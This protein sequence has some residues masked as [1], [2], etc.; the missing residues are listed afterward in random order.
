MG[1]LP[2][3][4]KQ[5]ADHAFLDYYYKQIILENQFIG[6]WNNAA[7]GATAE[8]NL[9]LLTNPSANSAPVG[10]VANVGL[11]L[12]QIKVICGTAA[13]TALINF[14]SGPTIT[15]NGTPI[16]PINRRPASAVTS[17]MKLYSQPTTS[18]NG[19]FLFSLASQNFVPEISDWLTVLDPA[20]SILVTSIMSGNT[21][22]ASVILSWYEL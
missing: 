21:A 1:A 10:T 15:G 6:A 4:A 18:A 14:Y 8:T 22:K 9:L 5:I 16:T 2:K 3:N 13:G 19:N 7:P 17:N 12:S 20:Q 11:F